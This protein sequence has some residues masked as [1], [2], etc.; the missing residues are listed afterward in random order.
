MKPIYKWVRGRFSQPDLVPS[1]PKPEGEPQALTLTFHLFESQED[2]EPAIADF[3]QGARI[4][5]ID[6][7]PIQKKQLLYM[8][9]MLR[10]LQRAAEKSGGSIRAYGEGWLIMLPP[11]VYLTKKN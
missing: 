4:L 11:D 7:T 8:K 10:K 9:T 6:V 3:R 5:F 1:S 2:L